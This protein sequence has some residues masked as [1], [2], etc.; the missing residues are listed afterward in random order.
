[1]RT[2]SPHDAVAALEAGNVA[3]VP[4]ET[5]VGLVAAESGLS[6][7]REIKGRDADKP[8][9]LLCD[10]AEEA[11]G[12]AASVPP[13]ARKLAEITGRVLS[14]SSWISPSAVPSE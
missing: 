10:S 7:V 13:L 8:I 6:R 9:A 1:M 3:L 5:V 14:R 2:V 12:L 11:L 4:T